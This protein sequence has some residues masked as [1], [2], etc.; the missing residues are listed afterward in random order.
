[1]ACTA[2]ALHALALQVVDNLTGKSGPSKVRTSSGMFLNR[3]EDEVVSAIEA[4]IQK[5]TALPA[6]NGEGL[7][8]LHYRP[9]EEYRCGAC[10]SHACMLLLLAC[11]EGQRHKLR[12][13]GAACGKED[14]LSIVLTKSLLVSAGRTLITSMT[15]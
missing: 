8:I 7:Q 2:A 13:L 6:E 1:M 10:S 12:L 11:S 5:H 14:D 4:R 3:G 9:D 15:L